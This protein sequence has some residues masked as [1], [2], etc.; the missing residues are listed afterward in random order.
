MS[1]A[2]ALTEVRVAE[3]A[4]GTKPSQDRTVLLERAVAVLDGA[5]A[6]DPAERDGGWYAS[7]LAEQLAARLEDRR[8]D[9]TTVLADS[10]AVVTSTYRLVPG[11]SPSST[12]TLLR[13]DDDRIDALVLGDSPLVVFRG[14][15]AE[16]VV[17]ERLNQVAPQ[18]RVAYHDRLAAGGG[19]DEAH[20]E[21]LR[22]LVGEQRRHR[23]RPDGYWIAEATPTAAG[24]AI[25]RSWPAG[26]VG[27]A[28]LASDG[29]SRGIG[30]AVPDW[31]TALRLVRE[32]G[33]DALLDAVR[34]PEQA[35]PDGRHW[36]R[37]KPYDDQALI[38][39]TFLDSASVS[40]F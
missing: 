15:R 27:T 35:D 21:L 1:A 29:V 11:H 30:R 5:S 17:D 13:W 18:Q 36:P 20:R 25:T 32:R 34:A 3:R 10:I 16:V 7:R 24:Q 6:P 9:L 19:Y 12:V 39:V 38:V 37:S 28:L 33:P 2:R 8:L 40:G 23:N 4:A 14:E 26:A 22:A 31:P